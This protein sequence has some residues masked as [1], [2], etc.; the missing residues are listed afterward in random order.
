M[1]ESCTGF[2]FGKW[3]LVACVWMLSHVLFSA[4]SLVLRKVA[5]R[6]YD[7]SVWTLSL[8][9]VAGS[10]WNRNQILA[11]A[12][13]LF[14]WVS[15]T[16]LCCID[17]KAPEGLHPCL[18]LCCLHLF[19]VAANQHHHLH[20][21]ARSTINWL[22]QREANSVN[23]DPCIAMKSKS[24]RGKTWVPFLKRRFNLAGC[25]HVKSQAGEVN[26]TSGALRC[27]LRIVQST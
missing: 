18:D 25:L 15:Q 22:E 6:I 10:K 7:N 8:C 26:S 9:R 21:F 4:L 12:V 2:L 14:Y 19:T 11:G 23:S 16:V 27:A 5:R 13:S 1:L 3:R 17:W 24:R 20:P